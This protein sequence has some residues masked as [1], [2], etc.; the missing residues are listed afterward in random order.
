MTTKL[1]VSHRCL[2]MLCILAAASSTVA[3]AGKTNVPPGRSIVVRY[4]DLDLSR[5]EGWQ[6]AYARVRAAARAVCGP[7]DFYNLALQ[8]WRRECY[9]TALANAVAQLQRARTATLR[10]AGTASQ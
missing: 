2:A 5:D 10:S 7:V 4:R 6:T 9:R 8:Q 3:V 1:R